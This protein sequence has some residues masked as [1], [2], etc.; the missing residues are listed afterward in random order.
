MA[1]LDAR[2]LSADDCLQFPWRNGWFYG[3]TQEAEKQG[4][5]DPC[6]FHT[7]LLKETGA[8]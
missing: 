8:I 4:Q 2:K 3:L 7:Q 1:L 5:P 6:P